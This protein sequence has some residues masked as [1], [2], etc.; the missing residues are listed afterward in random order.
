MFIKVTSSM[1][2]D[3]MGGRFSRDGASALF[4]FL[5]ELEE[6]TEGRELDAVAIK[7]DFSEYPSATEAARTQGGFFEIVGEDA[8]DGEAA[9]LEWLQDRASVIEFDG[10]VIVQNF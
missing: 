8:K 4:D 1:F 10:G 6:G 5:E 7:C 3:A 9:A 2:I